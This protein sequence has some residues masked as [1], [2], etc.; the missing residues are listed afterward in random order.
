MTSIDQQDERDLREL[1]QAAVGQALNTKQVAD[2]EKAVSVIKAIT[3]RAKTEL[4]NQNAPK[5]L[6]REGW[7]T[8]AAV[9]VPLVTLATLAFTLYTQNEERRLSRDAQDDLQW[10]E[11]VKDVL[12]HI[13]PAG[14]TGK[15]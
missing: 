10:R 11:T 4:D 7:K 1:R 9:V 2:I 3:D 8:F 13:S 14:T 15:P 12:A 6:R 5:M